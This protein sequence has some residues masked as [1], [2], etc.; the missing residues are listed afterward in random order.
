M[1][2]VIATVRAIRHRLLFGQLCG[3]SG[4]CAKFES[5]RAASWADW[6]VIVCLR[7]ENMG[8]G[9]SS[10]DM[11]VLTPASSGRTSLRAASR[12]AILQT[13]MSASVMSWCSIDPGT[14][15]P[16]QTSLS[17]CPRVD[18]VF[19]LC[20]DHCQKIYFL[21]SRFISLQAAAGLLRPVRSTNVR[22]EIPHQLNRQGVTLLIIRQPVSRVYLFITLHTSHHVT[23]R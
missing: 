2:P 5:V 10:D 12:S 17:L 6:D 19:P 1:K 14:T 15:H 7:G 20:S 16:L 23:T 3:F 9:L 18:M 8:C 21:S 22:R 4:D 11:V 13:S